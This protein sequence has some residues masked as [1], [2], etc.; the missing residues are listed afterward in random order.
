MSLSITKLRADLYNIID[1]V[2]ATGIPAAIERKGR[3][4]KIIVDD[5]QLPKLNNLVAHPNVIQCDP[6]SLINLDEERSQM[7]CQE[8]EMN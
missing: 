7:S 8:T 3:Q 4:I 2:I 6:E 1:N 5:N